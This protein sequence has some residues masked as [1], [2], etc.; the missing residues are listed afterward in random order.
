MNSGL[1]TAELSALRTFLAV[2]RWGA[3]GKAAEAL[4]L[5]QPAVSH[6][7][8]ALEQ[9]TGRPLF[10]RSGR[11][12]APTA[13]GHALAAEVSEH[14][15]AIER[16]MH[17]LRPTVATET[18]IVFLGGPI[19]LLTGI[20]PRLAP[21]LDTGLR[22]RCRHGLADDLL[23]GL[24]ADQLDIAVLTRIEG[25]PQKKL[26]L[27]QWQ[28]E[29]FV[30]IGRRG[31]APYDPAT[32]TRRFIGYGEEMPMTRRYFRT[33]WGIPAPAPALTVPN[34]RAVVD[35]VK[36]GAGLAVVPTYLFGQE[37]ADGTL[38]IVHTPPKPVLNSIYLATR[39][40]REHEPRVRMVLSHLVT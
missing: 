16:A 38:D 37:I 36:A 27:V 14:V 26:R 30:L 1:T 17:S 11:G 7:V 34:L 21:L 32:D 39:R 25:A 23:D 13:A 24:I 18:G 40:G 10:E 28:E 3:V 4:H 35:A 2:Y 12:I 31:E 5:S 20:V 6:H 33:C 19:E 15:D 8:K 22:I 9:V 29:E